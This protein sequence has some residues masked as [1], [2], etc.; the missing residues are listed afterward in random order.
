MQNYNRTSALRKGFM[1]RSFW[2]QDS[3]SLHDSLLAC[4][5]EH[6]D[7]KQQ[8]TLRNMILLKVLASS[9]FQMI[10]HMENPRES[11]SYKN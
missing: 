3:T 1:S 4:C 6:Q 8:V 11:I 2:S 5:S 9:C 7:Q 10:A